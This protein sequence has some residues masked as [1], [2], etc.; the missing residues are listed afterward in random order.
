[1][2][3]NTWLPYWAVLH[4]DVHQTLRGWL[5]RTWL[6]VALAGGLGFLLQRAAIHHEA[7]IVQNASMLVGELLQYTLII[8]SALVVLLCAGAISSERGTLADSVLC[9]GVS[10][11]Q[12][13]LGKLHGRMTTVL[14]SFLAFCVAILTVAVFLLKSDMSLLGCVLAVGVVGAVLLVIVSCG[15]AV[16][17]LVTHTVLGIAL[18]WIAV[19]ST[20]LAL[21]LVPLGDFSLMKLMKTLPAV[22]R[23][24]CDPYFELRIMG[25]CLA[26]AVGVATFG[27]I[28]FARRDV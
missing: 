27:M 13:F 19:Y 25:W 22:L 18:L 1:L 5:F 12:Y 23:G 9:R 21:T 28:C 8:G 6:L 3:L 2:R 10:R 14:G 15:V 26:A 4:M 11:Y 24:Q 17:A 20:G 7:G 16:S